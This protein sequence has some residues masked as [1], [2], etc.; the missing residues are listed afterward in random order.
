MRAAYDDIMRDGL[1]RQRA[2]RKPVSAHSGDAPSRIPAADAGPLLRGDFPR[3]TLT[4]HPR[5]TLGERT[6]IANAAT[7]RSTEGVPRRT[8]GRGRR[9]PNPQAVSAGF[10]P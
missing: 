8:R 7:S 4:W 6:G 10:H 2:R 3:R 5:R 9:E 1:K